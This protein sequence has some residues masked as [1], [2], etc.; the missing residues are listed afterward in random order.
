MTLRGAS[1][2]LSTSSRLLGVALPVVTTV[3][4]LVPATP[5][6]A[7]TYRF[8]SSTIRGGSSVRV[9]DSCLVVDDDEVATDPGSVPRF[10]PDEWVVEL[11][12][13][14]TVERPGSFDG[15]YDQD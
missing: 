11:R 6:A 12:E 5:S 14:R 9:A 8:D 4:L 2:T 7:Q 15:L 10:V 1:K 13:F 3:T